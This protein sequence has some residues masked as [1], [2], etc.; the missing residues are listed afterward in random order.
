MAHPW[1]NGQAERANAEVLRGLK[2]RSFKKKLEACSWGWVDKLPSVLWSIRTIATKP[3]GETPFFLV[4]KAEAV[5]PHEIK[6]QS[7]HVL[8][9]DEERQEA[10]RGTNLMLGE[11]AR[12]RASL[13]AVRYQQALRRYHCRNIRSRTLEVG[14]LVVRH[15]QSREGLHKI[16]PMWE[17]PFKVVHGSRPGSVRVET[18][19][20]V[21]IQNGWNI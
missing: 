19:D 17:G 18:Q 14:D 11:E 16:S 2:V 21:P 9:F 6:H 7:P 12:R 8:A 13:R 3:T 4:Y 20:G 10:E 15:V 1:S 5:L